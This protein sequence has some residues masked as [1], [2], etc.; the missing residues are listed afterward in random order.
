MNFVSS[1]ANGFSDRSFATRS[2]ASSSVFEPAMCHD[3]EP[4][5]AFCLGQVSGRV[6]KAAELNSV[7]FFPGRRFDFDDRNLCVTRICVKHISHPQTGFY[8]KNVSRKGAKT[9]S[10][11]AFF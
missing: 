3:V 4:V 1:V 10:A 9:L 8:E 7:R 5:R 11:A 6:G 2:F